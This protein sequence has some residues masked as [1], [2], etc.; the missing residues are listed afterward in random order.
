MNAAELLKQCQTDHTDNEML[1]T[2]EQIDYLHK[3]SGAVDTVR[4]FVSE[5]L[6]ND[7]T[8]DVRVSDAKFSSVK[9]T[10]APKEN[11]IVTYDGREY[12][13]KV[14]TLQHGRYIIHALHKAHHT[15]MRVKT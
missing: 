13:V 9:L 3:S 15:G 7:L 11:D 10:E 4:C 2:N 1:G 5:D 14:W 12:R 8:T 6:Y